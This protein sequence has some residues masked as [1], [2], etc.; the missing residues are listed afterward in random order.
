MTG[1]RVLYWATGSAPSWRGRIALEEKG[2]EYT[3]KLVNFAEGEH[4]RNKSRN[5][6]QSPSFIHKAEGTARWDPEV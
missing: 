6:N 1:K 2:L 5:S 4:H 3:A